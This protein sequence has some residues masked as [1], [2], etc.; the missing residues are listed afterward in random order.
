MAKFLRKLEFTT[1][2]DYAAGDTRQKPI[3]GTVNLYCQG[4][5]VAADTNSPITTGETN[6]DITVLDVGDIVVG[7]TLQVWSVSGAALG[8]RSAPLTRSPRSLTG[9]A[10]RPCG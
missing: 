8:P 5:T 1:T 4:A 2:G 3:A 9:P 10:T 7:D 6:Q